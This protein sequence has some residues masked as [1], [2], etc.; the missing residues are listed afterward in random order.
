MA[1]WGKVPLL[2]MYRQMA[3]RQQKKKDWEAC[4]CGPNA[5]WLL[6]GQRADLAS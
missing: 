6:Y 4:R 3:I 2:D 1:R 5:V